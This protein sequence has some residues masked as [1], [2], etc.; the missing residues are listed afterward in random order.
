[1]VI[2]LLAVCL[3]SESGG[4]T[5][6]AERSSGPSISPFNSARYDFPRQVPGGTL[7]G[8]SQATVKLAPCPTGVSG[9]DKNHY[10]YISGGSFRTVNISTVTNAAPITIVTG[11]PFDSVS[12]NLAVITGA[13]NLRAN[14]PWKITA[15]D[16]T[17][18]TLDNSNGTFVIVDAS[19]TAPIVITTRPG[20]QNGG[21]QTGDRV[22]ISG[23]GG[24]TAAN[25]TFTISRISET[26]FSLDGS[27]GNGPYAASLGV[28]AGIHPS[29][30]TVTIGPE[31]VLITG[32]TCKSGAASGTVVFTPANSHSGAW[33][34]RSATAGIQEAINAAQTSGATHIYIPGNSQPYPIYGPIT[35]P[36]N[37]LIEGAGA[38][39][40]LKLNAALPSMSILQAEGAA[41]PTTTSATPL[42]FADRATVQTETIVVT[43][44]A[45]FSPGDLVAIGSGAEPA[46][47][48]SFAQLNTV[49]AISGPIVTFDNSI[50]IPIDITLANSITKIVPATGITIRY[51]TL[52][53]SSMGADRYGGNTG[54]Y[55]MSLTNL[56]DSI[57]DHIWFRNFTADGALTTANGYGN[58]YTSLYD[59]NSGSEGIFGLGFAGETNAHINNI[60]STNSFGF[61]VG[62]VASTNVNVSGLTVMH[63]ADR[64]IKLNGV[65][66]STLQGIIVENCG[67]TGYSITQG[68]YRT[69]TR[70]IISTGNKGSEGV[71]FS[72]QDNQ[73][74]L[75]DGVTVSGN[76]GAGVMI[77]YRDHHNVVRNLSGGGPLGDLG[78]NNTMTPATQFR[79]LAYN[80]MDQS[81]P[82]DDDITL[83]FDTNAYDTGGIHDVEKDNS[84]FTIPAT[85]T[86]AAQYLIAAQVP[87]AQDGTGIRVLSAWKN[88]D[89]PLCTQTAVP[90]S[91]QDHYLSLSCTAVL[92]PGDYVEFKVFQDTAGSLDAL[93]GVNG[94]FGSVVRMQ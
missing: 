30:G 81:I 27:I 34:V 45:G 56:S 32:G 94:A 36:S 77:Y 38:G 93:G 48:N 55:G 17:T 80:S 12:G 74:N 89:A 65:A 67:F 22:T 9:S 72:D 35:V 58:H 76:A 82:A 57:I 85:E 25:G 47:G 68:T 90:S 4:Q 13:N 6:A 88:D 83:T 15:V 64:G 16:R 59:L 75:L 28:V 63:A 50:V 92:N 66:W 20:N 31:A 51:L 5:A 41:G 54:L 7:T 84:R 24:N 61:A 73:Y 23:V 26:Q 42:S 18:F 53:G 70:D 86:P 62:L 71:W 21:W 33:T 69:Q 49:R 3:A 11:S 52:D 40:V 60:I 91:S 19:N 87:F 79:S 1:M 46:H 39:T 14:G 8:G 44:P 78:A 2:F 37:F 10:L 43:S 29:G